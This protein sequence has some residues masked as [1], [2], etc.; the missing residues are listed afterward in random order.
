M[1]IFGREPALWLGVIGAVLVALSSFGVPYLN[2]G[3]AAAIV[4]LL[5]AGVTAWATRPVAP[6]LFT[7]VITA[8][9]ALVAEYG[10]HF[11]DV[12]VAGVTG[13]VLAVLALLGVR[14]QVE[15]KA[16]PA[17]LPPAAPAAFADTCC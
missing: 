1:K 16:F 9:S 13:T 4:A 8:A 6:A 3:Q 12:Q 7:G 14:S 5:T 17:P 11:S 2:A 15:P 10:L